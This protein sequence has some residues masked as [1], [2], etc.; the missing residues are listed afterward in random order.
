VVLEVRVLQE[1]WLE[2]DVNRIGTLNQDDAAT[3]LAN[4]GLTVNSE[5]DLEDAMTGF[6]GYSNQGT[7]EFREL[8]AWI[9]ENATT[10]T[11]T[12]AQIPMPIMSSSFR[13][14]GSAST[15]PLAYGGGVRHPLAVAAAA[16]Q[17]AAAAA[18]E[19][20]GAESPDSVGAEMGSPRRSSE[21]QSELPAAEP[22]SDGSL[23]LSP[24]ARSPTSSFQ[25]VKVASPYAPTRSSPTFSDTSEQ[26]PVVRRDLQAVSSSSTRLIEQLRRDRERRAEESAR[27]AM[28]HAMRKKEQAEQEEDEREARFQHLRGSFVP[29]TPH[30]MYT[31]YGRETDTDPSR[32]GLS[33]APLV[34]TPQQVRRSG[35][36]VAQATLQ[37][38]EE[39]RSPTRNDSS[40]QVAVG[41]PNFSSPMT[42]SPGVD[43]VH[44]LAKQLSL[45]ERAERHDHVRPYHDPA[46]AE[47]IHQQPAYHGANHRRAVV[48]RG[49][50]ANL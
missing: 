40:P 16:R 24:S 19:S 49:Q 1:Q 5:A 43:T 7:I 3:V 29:Y 45:T 27:A 20:A 17:S 31:I 48:Q 34:P 50:R 42:G 41:S 46:R 9:E 18:A 23:D 10:G 39:P 13:P 35:G 36:L 8:F 26:Q 44:E 33:L 14:L 38:Q 4:C 32:S 21:E 30:P 47:F 28:M 6:D 11:L 37:M 12:Q 2:V 25:V 22:E 15:S